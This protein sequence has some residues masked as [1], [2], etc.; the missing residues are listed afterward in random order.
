MSVKDK[1]VTRL[2]EIPGLYGDSVMFQHIRNGV[3]ESVRGSQVETLSTSLACRFLGLGIQKGDR[4]ISLLKDSPFWNVVEC[5][6]LK[7]GAVHVPLRASCTEERL[8]SVIDMTQPAMVVVDS[9]T[10][11]KRVRS[12][13]GHVTK[14]IIISKVQ[15][16]DLRYD[17]N[18][19]PSLD[20]RI[21]T[22]E[23]QDTAVILFT[24]GSSSAPK[25]VLLS[26]HN[27]LV[28]AKEFG[29]SD[30]FNHVQRS[31]SALPMSHSAARK[32]NYACQ[33]KGITVCYSAPTKSLSTNLGLFESHHVA[34]V[35]FLL[36]KLREEI[37]SNAPNGFRLKTVTCG[38]APLAADVW[39]WFD[40]KGI[41][42]Y[43]VYGL[44][45]T[46]S[47]L[48]YST[49]ACRKPGC[50]GVKA[51]NVE[52]D[53]VENN[54]LMVKGP[55]L[56]QGYLLPDGS[57]KYPLDRNGW[58]K[59]GDSV[60]LDADGGLRIM[61]RTDRSYK[62]QRGNRIH[63]EDIERSLSSMEEIQEAIVIHESTRLLAVVIPSYAACQSGINETLSKYNRSHEED[64]RIWR[65][66]ILES[67]DYERLQA[68]GSVKPDSGTFNKLM[69]E[70]NFIEL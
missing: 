19:I 23:P 65:Y 39:K 26:H 44:T 47:L 50:V 37:D 49:D 27:I 11:L 14:D 24:S 55:T 62:S 25:G 54:E 32:V 58:F 4:I 28:S 66:A 10:Q 5:A 15:E 41:K 16:S 9:A 43:E 8:T 48:S 20:H 59:T 17:E 68:T 13:T 29:N 53:I 22:I 40:S 2:F 35:P 61:G 67:A 1:E 30:V 36:Q 12:I 60:M 18:Q 34:L 56:F 63:P 31:L 7:I 46:A 70:L 6:I 21:G 3:L 45:E 51:Q 42:V 69:R 38:G 64:L 52:M 57:V 33:L